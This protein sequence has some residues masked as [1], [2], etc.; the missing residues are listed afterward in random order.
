MSL[1]QLRPFIAKAL[2]VVNAHKLAH[3]FYYNHIHGFN[4]AIKDTVPAVQ[5]AFDIAIKNGVADKGDYYEFGIFKGFTFWNAQ[6]KA[7]DEKLGKMRFFGFDSF[8]GLPVIEGL[9]VT[10]NEEFYEGQYNCSKDNVQ[11]NLDA[12]GVDWDRTHLIEGYFDVSLNDKTKKELKAK[13]VSI[14][15]IDCD[16]YSSTV[17]VL[18]FLDG[19]LMKG[20]VLMF[21]D[22]NCFNKDDEKG[23]RKAFAEFKQK[24]KGFAVEEL[25][26]YGPHGQVFQVTALK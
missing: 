22:W 10:D 2:R 7:N 21:D 20:S 4:A 13:K 18:N 19:M 24:H 5:Q 26:P 1:S 8:A 15:L 17:D 25:Y 9:D 12:K 14:A 11:K 3:F 23:Q 6:Q 16:L